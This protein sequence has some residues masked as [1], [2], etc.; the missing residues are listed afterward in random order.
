MNLYVY[1]DGD[2]VNYSDPTGLCDQQI[3]DRTLGTIKRPEPIFVIGDYDWPDPSGNDAA[4]GVKLPNEPDGGG[5]KG[6][7]VVTAKQRSVIPSLVGDCR[8]WV[9][10]KQNCSLLN[11]HC[12]SKPAPPP[13]TPNGVGP[14]LA[15]LFRTCSMH[16]P[17]MTL[18][19]V[20]S[21][22][23]NLN[24]IRNSCAICYP[25]AA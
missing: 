4:W 13:N 8:F 16:A 14:R 2:P 1:V 7:I 18:V 10:P 3:E 24:A 19:T 15:M 11:C 6:V 25:S 9:E 21:V 17:P 23:I 5:G 12:G 20:L 22:T